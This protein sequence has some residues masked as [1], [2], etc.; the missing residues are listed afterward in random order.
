MRSRSMKRRL[1]R[2]LG[3]FVFLADSAF[4]CPFEGILP[5]VTVHEFV[6]ALILSA[7]P[8]QRGQAVHR[9]RHSPDQIPHAV[10]LASISCIAYSFQ[11][12]QLRPLVSLGAAAFV[13]L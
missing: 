13:L 6:D 7:I 11:L 10:A 1:G 3:S 5:F 8:E 12:T 9:S 4:Y 2:I